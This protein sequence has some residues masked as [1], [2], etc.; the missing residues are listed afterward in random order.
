[1]F[2][3]IIKGLKDVWCGTLEFDTEPKKGSFNP[4]TSD[5]VYDAINGASGAKEIV[6]FEVDPSDPPS[7]IYAA[8]TEALSNNKLPAIR[9]DGKLY[10][11]T[12]TGTDRYDFVGVFDGDV[13]YELI[14]VWIGDAVN[15]DKLESS[16]GFVAVPEN[17]TAE[18]PAW[19]KVCEVEPVGYIGYTTHG[20]ALLFNLDRNNE[21]NE[22]VTSGMFVLDVGTNQRQNSNACNASWMA[23]TPGTD[24]YSKILGVKL[25]AKYGV[26]SNPA[27]HPY[28][29]HKVE[30]WVKY[31]GSNPILV[32]ALQN[33]RYNSGY[34]MGQNPYKFPE[35]HHADTQTTEP[36]YE[37]TEEY[38]YREYYYAAESP[39][40][41]TPKSFM[42]TPKSDW[43]I[44]DG[45][46]TLLF[47]SV[48]SSAS[49]EFIGDKMRMAM[50]DGET[51]YCIE[52]AKLGVYSVIGTI[53]VQWTG[54]P[55]NKIGHIY[56]YEIDF[57]KNFDIKRI[58]T[59]P[60]FVKITSSA[61]DFY[62][63]SVT[64]PASVIDAPIGVKISMSFQIQYLGNV[65]G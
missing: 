47:G 21:D 39:V 31:Y 41:T 33:A 56:G 64:M 17:G 3:K 38:I 23:Y 30:V 32:N 34:G 42:I 12:S 20:L 59:M 52:A 60:A 7:G 1:M 63:L 6:Y 28:P 50:R 4:V 58:G 43:L 61:Q 18:T 51:K 45:S 54:T 27:Y 11:Y 15:V 8:I 22:S 16:L 9:S 2:R 40:V 14:T 24:E 36:H 35:G 65:E 37:D 5:G 10:L 55:V 29:V 46:N 25:I 44:F 53:N 13:G 48:F 26:P 57:S 19:A 62:K 49:S